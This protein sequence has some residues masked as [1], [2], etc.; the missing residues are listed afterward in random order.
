MFAYYH[1]W[2][3]YHAVH[4]V[5]CALSK[6]RGVG[7][8]CSGTWRKVGRQNAEPSSENFPEEANLRLHRG[9]DKN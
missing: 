7:R 1:A 6:S 3:Q 4:D 5:S 2:T 8:L 9:L